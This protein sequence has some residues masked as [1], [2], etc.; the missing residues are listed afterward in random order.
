VRTVQTPVLTVGR[1]TIERI[2]P[3]GSLDAPGPGE[4]EAA[5]DGEL[6]GAACAKAL[7]HAD[8]KAQAKAARA[9]GAARVT[10]QQYRKAAQ[11]A[12]LFD[13]L[14]CVKT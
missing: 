9:T 14:A 3:H 8:A 5:G 10:T 7:P 12:T 13:G 6:D 11:D 1:F 4:D 2:D